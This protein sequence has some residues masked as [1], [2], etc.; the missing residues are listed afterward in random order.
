M[1]GEK[2]SQS[3]SKRMIIKVMIDTVTKRN[4]SRFVNSTAPLKNRFICRGYYK[5]RTPYCEASTKYLSDCKL[6]N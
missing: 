4:H 5:P 6:G 3:T 1:K 2:Q